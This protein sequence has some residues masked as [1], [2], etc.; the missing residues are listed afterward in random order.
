MTRTKSVVPETL[1]RSPGCD[2]TSGRRYLGADCAVRDSYIATVVTQQGRAYPRPM[3]DDIRYAMVVGSVAGGVA[4][5]KRY[6]ERRLEGRLPGWALPIAAGFAGL[7][8]AAVLKPAGRKLTKD[9]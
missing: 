3:N 8:A 6:T 1:G 9:A 4:F 2:R 7:A 5:A